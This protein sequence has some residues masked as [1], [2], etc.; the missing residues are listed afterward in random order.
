MY[1]T[2][3]AVIPGY[4]KGSCGRFGVSED[5]PDQVVLDPKF[6]NTGDC[7]LV[8]SITFITSFNDG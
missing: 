4:K 3:R 5:E 2:I 8:A 6:M 1:S 7:T